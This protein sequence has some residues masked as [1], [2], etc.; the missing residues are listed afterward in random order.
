VIIAAIPGGDGSWTF[1]LV[2]DSREPIDAV[3]VES[4]G[5]APTASVVL[6]HIGN[7]R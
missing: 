5:V 6:A 1:H 2:N 4:L 7:L 3:F